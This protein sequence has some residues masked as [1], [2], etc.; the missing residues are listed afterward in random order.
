MNSPLRWTS[1]L[2]FG[3]VTS[4]STPNKTGE[5]HTHQEGVALDSSA[6]EDSGSVENEDCRSGVNP[7]PLAAKNCVRQAACQWNGEEA[8]GKFGHAIHL[9]GDIDGDGQLDWVVGAPHEDHLA[10]DDVVLDDA[11]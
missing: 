7:S 11:G 6:P 1:A 8:D 3:C 5:T 10:A 4:Q 2:L 9:G